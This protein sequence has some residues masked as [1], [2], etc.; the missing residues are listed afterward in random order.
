[1]KFVAYGTEIG[2][3]YH[4]GLGCEAFTGIEVLVPSSLSRFRVEEVEDDED[5]RS[6]PGESCHARGRGMNA[7]QKRIKGE[8]A[9]LW[10]CDLPVEHEL[11]CFKLGKGFHE[12]GKGARERLTL[13]SVARVSGPPVAYPLI[14][15][16]S[17]LS[18]ISLPSRAAN[19]QLKVKT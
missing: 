13:P 17:R 1:M 12:L 19:S 15:S 14:G 3:P 4:R 10:N 7:L 16:R 9:S 11:P 8:V 5:C 2:R 6:L 18:L